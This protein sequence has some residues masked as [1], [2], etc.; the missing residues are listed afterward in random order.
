MWPLTLDFHLLA[1]AEP[2]G[3]RGTPVAFG[4]GA[5]MY[6]KNELGGFVALLGSEGTPLKAATVNGVALPSLA[7]R[8]SVP[9][10]LSV[11]PLTWIRH[12]DVGWHQR[13]VGRLLDGISA[14]AGLTIEYLRTSD[15]SAT[16]AGLHLG[17]AIDVPI[18]G[19]PQKEALALRLYGRFIAT[20]R[21]IL[22]SGLFDE[23][24]YTEQFFAGL[25]F[26]P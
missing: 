1:G 23:P 26:Y 25:A 7:D 20:P 2:H 19:G 11:R 3:E 15:D 8:I 6:W 22:D 14:Q 4:V 12:H 16:T 18:W 10:A 13:W 17:L 9:I 24:V 21:I 5:E